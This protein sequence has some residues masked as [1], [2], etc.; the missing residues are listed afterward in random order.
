MLDKL[1]ALAICRYYSLHGRLQPHEYA[2]H[3]AILKIQKEKIENNDLPFYKISNPGSQTSF[4]S[5]ADSPTPPITATLSS[6]DFNLKQYKI[7]ISVGNVSQSIDKQQNQNLDPQITHKWMCYLRSENCKNIENYIKKVVFYLHPSYKPNDIIELKKAPFKLYRHGWGEF[8]IH[9]QIHF[10]DSRNKRVDIIHA[11]KLDWALTGKQ[12]CSGETSSIADLL[13]NNFDYIEEIKPIVV[14]EK[15]LQKRQD[16]KANQ[17]ELNLNEKQIIRTNSDKIVELED[18]L[19]YP[20]SEFVNASGLDELIDLY[21]NSNSFDLHSNQSNSNSC[22]LD[23]I[24]QLLE[25]EK[26][27]NKVD[28]LSQIDDTSQSSSNNSSQV[29]QEAPKR[30]SQSEIKSSIDD[31]LSLRPKASPI[32]ATTPKTPLITT[33]TSPIIKI[34]S[35]VTPKI[36]PIQPSPKKNSKVQIKP[37]IEVFSQNRH[38]NSPQTPPVKKCH[39]QITPVVKSDSKMIKKCVIYKIE[40]NDIK[41]A[42]F[43][44]PLQFQ[45]KPQVINSTS[46]TTIVPFPNTNRTNNRTNKSNN[47]LLNDHNNCLPP[48]KI[49]KR[50]EGKSPVKITPANRTIP[51]IEFKNHQKEIVE[52]KQK[53][54]VQSQVQQQQQPQPQNASINQL[55]QLNQNS[56]KVYKISESLLQDI[57]K[58]NTYEDCLK[59]ALKFCPIITSNLSKYQLPFSV[60]SIK[61]WYSWPYAKRRANEW[62]RALTI[63]KKCNQLMKNT[64]KW[65]TKKV[66]IWL[67]ANGHTPLEYDISKDDDN[68]KESSKNGYVS[69]LIPYN[70]LLLKEIGNF[71]LR[72]VDN[73]DF[74]DVDSSDDSQSLKLSGNSNG[75]I[76]KHQSE[77]M[78]SSFNDN[79]YEQVLPLTDGAKYIREQLDLLGLKTYPV[80]LTQNIACNLIEEFLFNICK[81]FCNDLIRTTCSDIYSANGGSHFPYELNVLDIYKTINSHSKYD[82]LTNKFMAYSSSSSSSASKTNNSSSLNSNENSVNLTKSFIYESKIK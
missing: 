80:N 59:R 19:S 43:S 61:E 37:K 27:E 52:V 64:T 40:S 74:I 54:V 82:I 8:P 79:N 36:T 33:F 2:H 69:S 34:E 17:E 49:H 23:S 57:N 71:K 39:P 18:L 62:M 15:T 65:S 75:H 67:R 63:K 22:F 28:F 14:Q 30:Q 6:D 11:L 41:P 70:N 46:M 5:L 4:Q 47:P 60:Q 26:C 72:K 81:Q 29:F 68:I 9:V 32:L 38:M 56:I 66:M 20:A 35:P 16:L 50:F 48:T 25:D 13:I 10:K 21:T 78:P 24:T 7:K 77:N 51:S 53:P 55:A 73:C 76:H 3:P 42:T 58:F 12:K 31:L 45:N 1:R 44:S